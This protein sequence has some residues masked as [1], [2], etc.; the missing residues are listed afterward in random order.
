MDYMPNSGIKPSSMILRQAKYSKWSTWMWYARDMFSIFCPVAVK[1]T[2]TALILHFIKQ[3]S[4]MMY[5]KSKLFSPAIRYVLGIFLASPSYT[6]IQW[7]WPDIDIAITCLKLFEIIRT[8]MVQ[9]TVSM[10][11]G[12]SKTFCQLRSRS[13]IIW[14]QAKI[15]ILQCY[16]FH[17]ILAPFWQYMRSLSINLILIKGNNTST[18]QKWRILIE[19]YRVHQILL[20]ATFHGSWRSFHVFPVTKFHWSF[21]LTFI[22]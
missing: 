14:C 16:A 12:S 19:K 20:C 10:V 21:L 2:R 9:D 6:E 3:I 18:F 13:G 8:H 1:A 15:V 7:I 11:C 4:F 5:T 17:T 22:H